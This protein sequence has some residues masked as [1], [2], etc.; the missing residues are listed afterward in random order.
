M[1]VTITIEDEELKGMKNDT[2]RAM[3]KLL[4]GKDF[5]IDAEAKV[6]TPDPDAEPVVK[7]EVKEVKVSAPKKAGKPAAEK[8][9]PAKKA[10]PVK[11]AEP[12]AEPEA[13]AEPEPA[14]EKAAEP[15]KAKAPER[16]VDELKKALKEFCTS[17]DGGA[18]KIQAKFKELG[19][20]KASEATKEQ[21]ERVLKEVNE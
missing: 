10:E 5:S 19:I 17:H 18:A 11:E 8:L 14:A 6:C 16:T 2:V 7:A 20:K 21:L 12:E 13:E 15:E 4:T 3:A 9:K 1:K